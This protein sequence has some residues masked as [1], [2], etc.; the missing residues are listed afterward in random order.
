MRLGGDMVP[1][2]GTTINK[3]DCATN[4]QK[5]NSASH[6]YSSSMPTGAIGHNKKKS[7]HSAEQ[8]ERYKASTLIT[9]HSSLQ[10]ENLKQGL[11]R[12]TRT[13]VIADASVSSFFSLEDNLPPSQGRL[14]IRCDLRFVHIF[15]HLR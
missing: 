13:T 10:R 11:H 9:S 2:M 3:I 7:H 15:S 6:I 14:R 8:L 1:N 4:G 12:T 5:L